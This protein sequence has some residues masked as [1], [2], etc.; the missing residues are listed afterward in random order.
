[1]N[2]RRELYGEE[3]FLDAIRRFGHLD[4]VDFVKSIKNDILNFTGGYE[5]NDDITLVAI[6]EN[7]AAVDIKVN[8]FQDLF[9]TVQAD[10]DVTVLE[11]CQA[12]GISSSTFYRYKRIYEEGGYDLLREMLHGY[13]NL[14]L[15]HMSVELKTKMYDIIRNFPHYGPKKISDTLNTEEY[16][17]MEISQV[18]IYE[19]LKRAKL[20]TRERR[21]AFV[22]R[23]GK[24][25]LKPPGTPLL[26]LD[27]EVL[28]GFRS[29]EQASGDMHYAPPMIANSRSREKIIS[30][31]GKPQPSFGDRLKSSGKKSDDEQPALVKS[32]GEKEGNED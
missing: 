7:M 9:E 4:V 20:N 6:K 14:G 31:R 30:A 27:G 26:T 12:A 22:K 2:P 23:G 3:R 8:G 1:M 29:E 24:R 11:A 17:F 10:N 21:E 5:Q 15:R 25:R 13:T 18:L 19:E 32:P 28:V 16:G